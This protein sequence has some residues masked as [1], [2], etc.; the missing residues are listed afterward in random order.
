MKHLLHLMNYAPLGTRAIDH[1]IVEYD[2]QARERGWSVRFGFTAVP[3]DSMRVS[4]FV[5]DPANIQIEPC[6]VLQTSFHSAFEKQ[7]LNLKRS[8]RAK[9]LAIID[10]SS[11]TGPSPKSL[12]TPLRKLRGWQVGKMI[13]AVAC[14][15]QYNAT[16][17]IERVFLPAGKVHVVHN[18][19]ELSRFPFVDR[20]PR[21]GVKIVYAGQLTVSKGVR[22]L[23][24][25]MKLVRGATLSIAGSGPL[26]SELAGADLLGH[27]A[28][29]PALFQSA[30]IV[31][32][33]SEWAEAFGLVVIEAMACG[34]AVVA[35]DAGALPEVV[36]EAGL[37][38]K[39]GDANDLAA[40][41]QRLI[42]DSAQ[43]AALAK[44]GRARVEANYQLHDCVRKHLDI[45][46][47]LA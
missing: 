2:R 11:G 39:A 29:M 37:I 44:R 24:S 28:D 35:S 27:V 10:H 33:P 13:D 32:V 17:D 15:S 30:D 3:P 47:S 19:I 18:G 41:L 6:D 14:V 46:D 26:A 31:V 9:K 5:Y 38:F 7:I 21:E 36:G 40:K 20:E 42:D 8:G 16:R 43:R 12:L 23:M 34:A 22:T 45:V 1:F 4:S 25:A